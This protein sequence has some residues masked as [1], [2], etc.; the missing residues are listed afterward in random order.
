S[1]WSRCRRPT[2]GR[3]RPRSSP[4]ARRSSGWW[5]WRARRSSP[6]DRMVWSR[7]SESPRRNSARRSSHCSRRRYR[8]TRRRRRPGTASTPHQPPPLRTGPNEGSHPSRTRRSQPHRPRVHPRHRGPSASLPPRNS[9]MPRLP[10]PRRP[11]HRAP[12]QRGTIRPRWL[13]CPG[14]PPDHYTAERPPMTDRRTQGQRSR[15]PSGGPHGARSG[16]GRPPTRSGRVRTAA[17]TDRRFTWM[18]TMVANI[19][20]L[21]LA[22]LLWVQTIGG[23]QPAA[24]AAWQR[25]VHEVRPATRGSIVDLNGDPIAFTRE[26]RDLS[27]Q[28]DVEER[29]AE[30]RRELDSTAPTWDELVADIADEF[31]AVLG[32]SV[33]REEIEAKLESDSG[34]TY[35][36]RNVDVTDA[37]SITEKFPMIGAERVDIREYPGGALG[38]NVV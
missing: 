9:P 38:A 35:L 17:G 7:S 20:V 36:V 23:N 10:S 16:A 3:G 27:I 1:G 19:M 34:F 5:G 24:R 14:R 12:R 26:A 25:Q 32:D 29:N 33:D 11:P 4:P 31:E 30:E 8:P 2:S 28:P 13:R 37:N 15:V 21:S 18:R 22:K 6:G